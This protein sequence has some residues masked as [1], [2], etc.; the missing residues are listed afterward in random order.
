MIDSDLFR[1]T[2]RQWAAGVT[3]ITVHGG[4]RVHG[5]TANSFT[6][7]SCEPPLLLFCVGLTNDTHAMLTVGARVGIN[8]LSESQSELSKRFASKTSARYQFDDLD[9]Y[10]GPNGVTLFR[11]CAAVM[12]ADVINAYEA[13]DHTIFVAHILSAH[14][15]CDRRPLVYSQ[16]S[17]VEIKPA[18]GDVKPAARNA[19]PELRKK[20]LAA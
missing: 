10:V 7:V 18:T 6:S 14:P 3:V 1:K 20:M 4:G 12:E 19:A 9:F 13:G 15:D 11:H 8:L 2:M 17:Y 5:M 16:G